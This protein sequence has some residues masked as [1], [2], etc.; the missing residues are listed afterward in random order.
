VTPAIETW[1][2]LAIQIPLVGIF[3]YFT[4]IIIDKFLK[5]IDTRDA[6]WREFFNQQRQ[7]NNEAISNMAERFAG[8]IRSL[9]KEIAELRGNIRD[10]N[11]SR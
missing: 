4:L 8:E 10:I 6:A 7:A 11:T 3:V 9:G 2:G 1:I 5:S